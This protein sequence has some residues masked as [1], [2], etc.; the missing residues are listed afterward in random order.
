MRKVILT[1]MTSTNYQIYTWND[2]SLLLD[3][4]DKVEFSINKGAITGMHLLLFGE[5][6][7]FD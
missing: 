1:L 5:N 6:I 3:E 7:Q 4:D 2:L